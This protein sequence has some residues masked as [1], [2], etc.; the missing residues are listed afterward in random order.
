MAVEAYNAWCKE[1]NETIFLPTPYDM[2]QC[3]SECTFFYYS[4]HVAVC[5]ISRHV[6][7]CTKRCQT[8]EYE[9]QMLC[10]TTK[11]S[12]G[13]RHVNCYWD[14]SQT[15][16]PRTFSQRKPS[17]H[18]KTTT[19]LNQLQSVFYGSQREKLEIKVNTQHYKKQKQLANKYARLQSLQRTD[20]H[21]YFFLFLK[22]CPR[23]IRHMPSQRML[24]C[25]AASLLSFWVMIFGTST[26]HVRKVAIF[27]ATCL[28]ELAVG[29]GAIFP[30]ISWLAAAFQ[31]L[32]ANI[33]C[34]LCLGV[35]N[36]S[37]TTM[38]SLIQ[39]KCNARQPKM[40]YPIDLDPAM[41]SK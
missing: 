4:K 1:K 24:R 19:I 28:S 12:L 31:T 20:W 2:H 9:G 29:N 21:K 15:F 33:V 5:K 30:K 18:E 26:F 27:I 35:A 22:N 32:P 38:L 17:R 6:H 13:E 39:E 16:S 11:A 34:T 7:T 3:S 23:K 37:T 36:R 41:L 8:L 25:L 40:T 10:G 14:E